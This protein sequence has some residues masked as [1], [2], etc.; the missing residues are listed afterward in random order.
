M[1]YAALF[2]NAILLAAGQILWKQ[3]VTRNGG[4]DLGL[5]A[6]PG[7]WG[8]LVAYGLAT[9][10]WLFVLSRLPLSL[11]YP[12]QA[13]AYVLGALAGLWLFAE[14]VPPVRWAGIALILLGVG[15]VASG[16]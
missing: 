1:A 13:T 2:A 15:L 8:G 3:A 6:Q 11:A 7:V 14:P 12:L 9:V 4:F 16:K 10:L 5:V